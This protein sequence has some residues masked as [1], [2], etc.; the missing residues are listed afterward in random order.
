MP[1]LLLQP[2][3]ASEAD[4][5]QACG[6]TTTIFLFSFSLKVLFWFFWF[7]FI[8]WLC[9]PQRRRSSVRNRS[10]LQPTR[11]LT[12]FR[13]SGIF[14]TSVSFNPMM[15]C[16]RLVY[17]SLTSP[18]KHFFWKITTQN[19]QLSVCRPI[20]S[21]TQ[22]LKVAKLCIKVHLFQLIPPYWTRH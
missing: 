20:W 3:C 22:L 7:N 14:L 17:R 6:T 10:G 1:C 4:E 15:L 16:L 12:M 5:A 13:L 9:F 2:V 18:K 19:L 8:W 21:M 11:S